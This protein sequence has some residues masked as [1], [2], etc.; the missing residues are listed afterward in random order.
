MK[1]F[2]DIPVKSVKN[3]RDLGG[4]ITKDF[5]ITKY[6]KF[7]RSA[8][9]SK[10]LDEDI[11]F[12]KKYG[13]KSILDLRRKEE[14][15]KSYVKKIKQHFNYY[16]ISLF[17]DEFSDE[18]V[19][20]IIYGKIDVSEKYIDALH[21]YKVIKK[22][23]NLIINSESV[24]F[25]CFEGKDRTGIVSMLLLGIS[26]VSNDK[27]IANYEVSSS[28]LGYIEK[29]EEKEK[30]NKL[31]ITSP[32]IMKNTLNLFLKEFRSFENYFLEVG[33]SHDE[34]EQFKKSFLEE[35]ND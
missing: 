19:E 22:I 30:L 10:I 32:Y 2:V 12:L 29:Y 1:K 24:L 23:L 25:H 7:I 13:V 5:K 18:V 35:I 17:N 33:I 20:D 16:N 28:Y 27:I 15:E 9:L 3:I 11:Q 14:V 6:G 21:D 26:N 34:I 4:I 8:N 31:R